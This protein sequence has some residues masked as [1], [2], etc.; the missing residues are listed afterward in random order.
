VNLTSKMRAIRPDAEVK[1][2]NYWA[3]MFSQ[4][5]CYEA[6]KDLMANP[7][8]W[9]NDDLGYPVYS[10]NRGNSYYDFRL[11]QARNLWIKGDKN[12]YLTNKFSFLIP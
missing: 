10:D 8:L 1:I 4:L 12:I 11:E 3:V 5:N 2:L 7:D 6:A 9:L